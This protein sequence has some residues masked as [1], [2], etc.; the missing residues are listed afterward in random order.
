MLLYASLK[1]EL[2]F[3]LKQGVFSVYIFLT[4]GYLIMLSLMPPST[5]KIFMP[6]VIFSDPSIIGLFFVG[7][8]MMFEKNQGIFSYLAITPLGLKTYIWSKLLSFLI[9]SELAGFAIC[10]LSDYEAINYIVLFFSIMLVSFLFTLI[11]FLITITCTTMNQYF[12]RMIPVMIIFMLPCFGLLNTDL[13]ILNIFPSLI[14]L[15]MMLHAFNDSLSIYFLFYS[16]YLLIFI[17]VLY[18]LVIKKMRR[19][20]DFK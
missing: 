12:M 8:M 2:K 14:G 16:K 13:I 9:L 17:I 6:I 4:V 15:K 18:W 20:T 7:A 3:L 5:I 19:M 1:T 11:G 10:L